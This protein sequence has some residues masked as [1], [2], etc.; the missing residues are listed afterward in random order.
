MHCI[1][2]EEASYNDYTIIQLLR[3]HYL[4]FFFVYLC[5]LI[6]LYKQTDYKQLALGWQTLLH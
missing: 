4:F 3:N 5:T 1:F 6:F 2:T